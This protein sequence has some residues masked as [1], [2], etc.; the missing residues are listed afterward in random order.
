MWLMENTIGVW[1]ARQDFFSRFFLAI[2]QR[3]D[4]WA[5]F[6]LVYKDLSARCIAGKN[7]SSGLNSV[8]SR[9]PVA[10]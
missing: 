9:A 8:S 10:L 4:L 7:F 3:L 5:P 1:F 6:L 2:V